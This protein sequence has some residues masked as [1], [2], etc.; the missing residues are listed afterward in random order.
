[1]K[2]RF[3]LFDL[4]QGL[5]EACKNPN[6]FALF[7]ISSFIISIFRVSLHGHLIFELFRCGLISFS[8]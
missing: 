2:V 1:M 5:F 8:N 6:S 4:H 3:S 7:K